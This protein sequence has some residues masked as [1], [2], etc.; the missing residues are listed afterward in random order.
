MLYFEQRAN[1]KI[2]FIISLDSSKAFDTKEITNSKKKQL[3]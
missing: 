3:V 1:N 2:N